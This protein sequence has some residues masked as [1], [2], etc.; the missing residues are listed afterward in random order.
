MLHIRTVILS[1]VFVVIFVLTI[2]SMTV[3]TEFVPAPEGNPAGVLESQERSA[4][5]NHVDS[6]RL[7]RFS[8]GECFDVP[9]SE[10][11]E[12]QKE[13]QASIHIYRSRLDECYDVP[14]RELASCRSA[15][16][17]STP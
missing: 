9:I 6:I 5:Q 17:A 4:S 10:A 11:A 15:S 8:L 1:V 7:Y 14:L 2:G 12:C 3:R 16:Q 13:S